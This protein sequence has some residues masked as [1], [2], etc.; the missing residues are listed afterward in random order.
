MIPKH[1]NIFAFWQIV[2]NA[3]KE[4]LEGFFFLVS[5]GFQMKGLLCHTFTKWL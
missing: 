3:F 5:S 2:L 4:Q 1:G